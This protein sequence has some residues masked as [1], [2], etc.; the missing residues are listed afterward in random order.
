MIEDKN[1]DDYSWKNEYAY[2]DNLSEY[3]NI[4]RLES[5]ND[6]IVYIF[7]LFLIILFI[8]HHCIIK[9]PTKGTDLVKKFGYNPSYNGYEVLQ[10][11]KRIILHNA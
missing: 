2:I 6:F 7:I 10:G 1:F 9:T 11:I 8:L 3:E 4:I 5:E